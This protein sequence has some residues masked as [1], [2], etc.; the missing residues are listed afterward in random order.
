MKRILGLDIGDK[1]IGVAV[2][3]EL[4]LTA[5]GVETIFTRGM[6]NDI[7]RVCELAERYD[8]NR[9]VSGLPRHLNGEEGIQASKVHLFTDEL[10]KRGFEVRFMDERL[11]TVRAEKLLIESGVR[12]EDRKKVIDKIA[13]TY[14][15][16]SF[17]DMGGWREN[18][19]TEYDMEVF[20]LMEGYNMDQDD[21]VVL[22]DENNKE[23]KFQHLMT[24]EY[25]GKDYVILAAAEEMEDVGEDEAVVLRI[26]KDE[27][28]EDVYATITDDNELE[29][30][31]ERYLEIAGDDE[32]E[33]SEDEEE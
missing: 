1:R 7:G 15:L 10:I 24:L 6:E 13:A 14:I 17:L 3:D 26:D 9:I 16:E 21:I 20:R 29:K 32:D 28:G 8:T 19:K 25:E 12:R 30:V 22:F 4:G 5:Q 31:F 11:T 18:T 33:D 23:C 2:S 27:N